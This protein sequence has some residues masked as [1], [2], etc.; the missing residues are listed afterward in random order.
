MLVVIS[1]AKRL[2]ETP[3]DGVE[4]TRPQFEAE[5]ARLAGHMRQL[6]LQK[7]KGLMGLSDD[8][9]KLN[10]RRFAGFMD[11]PDA[12]AVKPAMYLY[13]GD[14]YLGLEAASLESETV[15][16]A[17]RHL[18]I[19]S[20]LYGLLRPLDGIQPH[21]L[22]MGSRLKTRRGGNLYEF[23]RDL[24]ATA[25][26]QAAEEAGTGVLVNCA[27]QEYFGAVDRERLKL[28]V[29]T[30]GFFEMRNGA[31]KVVS[32]YAKKARGAMARF[33]MERRVRDPEGLKDFDFG[34]YRYDPDLSREGQPA[35]VR[36]GEE[37][38]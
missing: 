8:L 31:P 26:N 23:W 3:M 21:R 20:G 19:L 11:T 4:T 1:P 30:P 12:A 6:S 7:L 15:A 29:I 22:E 25:L 9:A 2:N 5:A 36:S 27:S 33:V 37:V 17:Q 10:R 14:T 35:F 28:E 18:R 38:A 32:F 13:A 24:P 16:Y 34:G